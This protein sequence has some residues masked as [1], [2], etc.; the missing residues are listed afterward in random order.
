MLFTLGFPKWWQS[1][2]DNNIK[3]SLCTLKNNYENVKNFKI[4]KSIQQDEVLA[5][6]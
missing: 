4:V 6:K 2:P 3:F 1:T 5:D